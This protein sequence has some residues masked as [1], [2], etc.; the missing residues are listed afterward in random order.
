[1]PT[2][3]NPTS[4]FTVIVKKEDA[5]FIDVGI[6]EAMKMIISIGAVS[7]NEFKN[8]LVEKLKV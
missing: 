2:C 7:E 5:K 6:D 1:M 3:P 4:G 8:K